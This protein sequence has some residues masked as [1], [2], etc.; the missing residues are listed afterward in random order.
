[1][2]PFRVGL[3]GAGGISRTYMEAFRQVPEGEVVAVWSRQRANA[4]R[5]A[6]EFEIGCATDR[7]EELLPQVDVVCVNSPNACHAPHAISAAGSGKHVIVEKPMA[8]D[9]AGAD[10]LI[11]GCREAGVALSVGYC[12]RNAPEIRT[13]RHLVEQGLL[14]R[15]LTVQLTCYLDKPPSYWGAGYTGRAYSPWRATLEGSGGGVLI[16]NMSHQLDQIRY[17]V[18]DE[19][20]VSLSLIHI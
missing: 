6:R 7:V 2:K 1:M 3:I 4:E 12:F 19:I 17:I 14:G 9:L 5:F 20:S 18:G 16:M 8:I 15:I 11:A 13:A 10:R